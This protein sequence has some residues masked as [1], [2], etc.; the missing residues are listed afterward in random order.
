M[1]RFGA[2]RHR[3]AAIL[4]PTISGE[5]YE[6]GPEFQDRFVEQNP[7]WAGYFKTSSRAG[8]SLFDLP[9]FIVDRLKD[10]GVDA[11]SA[12]HCTYADENRYFSYRRTTHRN[13]PDYGRQISAICIVDGG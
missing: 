9:A 4:G 2:K 7:S 3:I 8:H 12:G 11:Y 1:E 10:S 13:E 5:N 6:V